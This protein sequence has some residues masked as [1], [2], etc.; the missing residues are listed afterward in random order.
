MHIL[1]SKSG[2]P[3]YILYWF[4]I[5]QLLMHTSSY[6]FLSQYVFLIGKYIMYFPVISYVSF[7]L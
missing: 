1:F 6:I 5:S 3:M 4:S 7:S 2:V